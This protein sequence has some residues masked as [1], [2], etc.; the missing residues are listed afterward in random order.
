MPESIITAT[1]ADDFRAFARL[2]REFVDWCRARYDDDKWFV[3][4]AFSHQSLDAE[5]ERLPAEYGPPN[6]RA[7]LVRVADIMRKGNRLATVRETASV[8][9][10]VLA[11]TQARSGSTGIVDAAGKLLGIFTDGD[12]RRHITTDAQILEKGVAGVMTKSPQTVR[13]ARILL[14][15]Q[16]RGLLLAAAL[17]ASV[18]I[19]LVLAWNRWGAPS[20]SSDD[21]VVT[22]ERIVVSP[23]PDWIHA[24]VK[25]EVVKTASLDRLRLDE[26]ELVTKVAQA[27][28]LHPWVARVVR[29][30]KRFPA[31]VLVEL[32]YD[33]SAPVLVGRTMQVVALGACSPYSTTIGVTDLATTIDQDCTYEC[34]VTENSG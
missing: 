23:T 25:A 26:G 3:D 17:C 21:Y 28:D 33:C 19:G 34:T 12:L 27:F 16:Y 13:A 31:Q 11:M 14:R 22:P 29:V 8:R 18:L 7:L 5:L 4:A 30:E 1:T 6:G 32:D 24:D 15:P 9:D 20:L 2:I 10:A